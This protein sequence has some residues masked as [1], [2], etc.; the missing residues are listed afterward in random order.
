M[1]QTSRTRRTWSDSY[2][3]HVF[4]DPFT[5]PDAGVV[6]LRDDIGQTIVDRD[7][8]LDVGIVRQNP[9]ERRP[10]S[11]DRGMLARRD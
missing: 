10:E 8:D 4:R 3:D 5:Q 7:F 9:R 6:T 1:R 2:R 11:R